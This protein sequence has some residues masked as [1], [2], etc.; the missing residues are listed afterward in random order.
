VGGDPHQE[1]DNR[2]QDE[3]G[4]DDQQE[5]DQDVSAEAA[6]RRSP[7]RASGGLLGLCLEGGAHFEIG[8][9]R[10]LKEESR[11][12]P[13]TSAVETAIC[14][15]CSSGRVEISSATRSWICTNR[16]SRSAGSWV[17]RCCAISW[18]TSGSE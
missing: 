4:G 2:Q 11:V 7:A 12:T 10:N 5:T 8:E 6:P 14:A 18:S 1:E 17:P 3:D 15:P 13:S 16:A 9:M